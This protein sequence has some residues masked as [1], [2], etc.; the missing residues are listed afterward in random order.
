MANFLVLI[1]GGSPPQFSLARSVGLIFLANLG[2][3]DIK[4]K[5]VG[6]NF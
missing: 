6:K 2:L 4:A 5:L 3:I 1:F